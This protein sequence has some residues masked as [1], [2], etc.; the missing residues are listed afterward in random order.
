[1]QY[2]FN[3]IKLIFNI[4]KYSIIR[5][6]GTTILNKDTGDIQECKHENKI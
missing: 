1:M 3:K 6:K 2:L 5:P 4:M